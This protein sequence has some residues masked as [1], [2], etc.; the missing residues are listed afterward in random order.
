M[1]YQ[2]SITIATI[3]R[4]ERVSPV[5]IGPINFS[6]VCVKL[7]TSWSSEDVYRVDNYKL[8]SAVPSIQSSKFT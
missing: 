4:K 2:A 7:F 3:A 5:L 6:L 8:W 1:Y